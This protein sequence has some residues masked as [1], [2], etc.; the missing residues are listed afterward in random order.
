MAVM[1]IG[2]L[3][4]VVCTIN[5]IGQTGFWEEATQRYIFGIQAFPMLEAENNGLTDYLM[6]DY[7][8]KLVEK[9]QEQQMDLNADEAYIQIIRPMKD[10]LHV[11]CSNYMKLHRDY[12]IATDI[13][14]H[15]SRMCELKLV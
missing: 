3:L 11:L 12:S 1:L 13:Q 4:V 14:S 7:L 2:Y 10:V 9:I 15:P 6:E 5:F 8:T